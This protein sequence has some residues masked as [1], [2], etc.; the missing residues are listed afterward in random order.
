MASITQTMV[1]EEPGEADHAVELLVTWARAG[2]DAASCP[3]GLMVT[4]QL[5]VGEMLILSPV[6]GTDARQLSP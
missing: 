1:P 5:V 4:W 6:P 2:A 3:E